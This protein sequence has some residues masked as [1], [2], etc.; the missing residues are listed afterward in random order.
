MNSC[1]VSVTELCQ[2]SSPAFLWGFPNRSQVFKD[3]FWLQNSHCVF[4]RME[5]RKER[6]RSLLDI[7][8]PRKHGSS[9]GIQVNCLH[10]YLH[11]SSTVRKGLNPQSLKSIKPQLTPVQNG[12][13]SLPSSMIREDEDKVTVLGMRG[14]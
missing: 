14:L 4:R 2:S 6:T 10:S 3:S 12:L 8:L 1:G 9:L 7:L 13:F 5:L 11:H